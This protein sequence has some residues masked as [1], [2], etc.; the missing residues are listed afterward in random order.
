MRKQEKMFC[1]WC[2][3]K[4]YDNAMAQGYRY[5]QKK[6]IIE[7]ETKNKDHDKCVKDKNACRDE[8]PSQN[9]HQLRL[10]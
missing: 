9:Q 8:K 4:G 6:R 7:H 1:K 2:R 5:L 10:F 3:D